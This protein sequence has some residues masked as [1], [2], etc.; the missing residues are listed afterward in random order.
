MSALN[1]VL[2]V[3]VTARQ[4]GAAAADQ[5]D[6][7]KVAVPMAAAYDSGLIQTTSG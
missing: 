1:K 2:S 6:A 7:L 3:P 4:E 5:T